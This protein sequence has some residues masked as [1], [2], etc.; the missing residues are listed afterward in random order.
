MT[1]FRIIDCETTGMEDDCKVCEIGSIDHNTD[2]ATL[3]LDNPRSVL[4]NPGVPIP[5][6]ASAIHHITDD[7]VA[8]APLFGEAHGDFLGAD[9]YV[10]HN[11]RFDQRFLGNF[12]K[13]WIDTYRCALVCWPDAPSHSNQVLRYHLGLESPPADIGHAHRALYDVYVT[14]RL[15]IEVMKMMDL[16]KML[17]VSSQPALLPLVRFGKHRGE[18]F[19]ALPDGY[20]KWMQQQ[21][22]DED[23]KHTVKTELERRA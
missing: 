18:K 7:M 5:A 21:D 4:I 13:P 3:T 2:P 9:Y 1:L 23:I 11:S 10:A 20:L 17:E 15:F 22:F 6:Q 14:A 8:G 19:S 12:G 16:E